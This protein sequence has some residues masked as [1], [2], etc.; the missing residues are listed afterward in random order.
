MSEGPVG[1]RWGEVKAERQLPDYGRQ[2]EEPHEDRVDLI[3]KF[4]ELEIKSEFHLLSR[5]LTYVSKVNSMDTE[6]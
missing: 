5:R 1:S 3:V 6:A 2:L 4:P